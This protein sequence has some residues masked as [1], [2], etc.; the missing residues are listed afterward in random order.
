MLNSLV[1]SWNKVVLRFSRSPS[2]KRW[3]RPNA[4]KWNRSTAALCAKWCI[5]RRLYQVG[6]HLCRAGQA[7]KISKSWALQELLRQRSKTK[8]ICASVTRRQIWIKSA[9]GKVPVVSQLRKAHWHVQ[10]T[11]CNSTCKTNQRLQLV[12]QANL[13][14]S[15]VQLEIS[16][17]GQSLSIT[18]RMT[19]RIATRIRTRIMIV[20][21]ARIS[22]KRSIRPF[23]RS[24]R[25]RSLSI[26]T[27]SRQ[28]KKKK[29]SQSNLSSTFSTKHL[30]QSHPLVSFRSKTH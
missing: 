15:R 30:C 26:R 19:H 24:N 21:T 11:I 25:L 7:L 16:Q 10:C 13:A 1:T 8:R 18:S 2:R 3:W 4:S 23:L 27:K 9:L 12:S 29:K 6:R 17:K 20:R 28:L 14:L 22:A 5:C